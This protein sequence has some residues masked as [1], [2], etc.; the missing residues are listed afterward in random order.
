MSGHGLDFTE[1]SG[2]D[3]LD[4]AE[5]YDYSQY[6]KTSGMAVLEVFLIYPLFAESA[7]YLLINLLIN[8]FK[9]PE[10]HCLSGSWGYL[11]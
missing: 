10:I 8:T 2:N 1:R 4:L 5:G 6:D 9:G 3:I 7:I 11:I